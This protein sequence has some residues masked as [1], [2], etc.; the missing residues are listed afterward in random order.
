MLST[1]VATTQALLDLMK[2]LG[3]DRTVPVESSSSLAREVEGRSSKKGTK[4]VPGK[5]PLVL[6]APK[7]QLKPL[8]KLTNPMV[9]SPVQLLHAMG[10]ATTSTNTGFAGLSSLWALVRYLWAFAGSTGQLT[11]SQNARDLAFHQKTLFSEQL[12]LGLTW[13]LT[14]RHY[15]ALYGQSAVVRIADAE[16][17]IKLERLKDPALKTAVRVTRRHGLMPDGIAFT[18]DSKSA[19]SNLRVLE[20]KGCHASAVKGQ[21]REMLKALADARVQV[22]SLVVGGATLDGWMACAVVAEHA[23]KWPG[24]GQVPENGV[25]LF[26][27]DP[28]AGSSDTPGGGEA[29]VWQ[30]PGG[31]WSV[32]DRASFAQSLDEVSRSSLLAYAGFIEDAA[33][34]TRRTAPPREALETPRLLG[35]AMRLDDRAAGKQYEGTEVELRLAP[36]I[37]LRLFFGLDRDVRGALAEG[38]AVDETQAFRHLRGGITE[39]YALETASDTDFEQVR[40]IG[41]DGTV[42]D[43]RVDAPRKV[44]ENARRDLPEEPPIASE[45]QQQD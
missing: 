15:L 27:L 41:S 16:R 2:T 17:A 13:L 23:A 36:E 8:N 37:A 31:A 24:L 45:D 39:A 12:G 3:Q 20:S 11:V 10:K 25:A 32:R 35:A 42:F 22:C 7:A 18:V 33:R 14:E 9:V 28:P 6:V 30:R 21:P 38:D 44:L 34:L 29:R 1:A 40:S 43:V 4:T 26:A 5:P 19:A